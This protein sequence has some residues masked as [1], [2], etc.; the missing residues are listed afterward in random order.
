M[1]NINKYKKENQSGEFN[2]KLSFL[3]FWTFIVLSYLFIEWIYN[4]HL[5]SLL[6]ITSIKPNN[7][8]YTEIFGKIIASIGL[9]LI[10]K[11][12]FRY[13]GWFIFI[14]GTVFSYFLLSLFFT[15]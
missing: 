10:I 13:K 7:F 12:T 2:Q 15:S 5:L 4:Q 3:F 14:I 8:Y 9:N 11:E 6:T 1:I